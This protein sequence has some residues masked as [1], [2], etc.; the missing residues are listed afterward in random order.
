MQNISLASQIL[1]R[2]LHILNNHQIIFAGDIQDNFAA[3]FNDAIVLTSQFHHAKR[4]KSANIS[5]HFGTI[6]DESLVSSASLLVYY[7]PK[8]KEEAL[9]QLTQLLSIIPKSTEI[10]IVGENRV[11]VRSV[12]NRFDDLLSLQKI[13]T[14][15][16]CSLYYAKLKADVTFNVDNYWQSYQVNESITHSALPGVFSRN[17]LDA[18]SALLINSMIP[19]SKNINKVVN[20]QHTLAFLNKPQLRADVLDL[21]CG[22]GIVPLFLHTYYPN[23]QWT[24]ADAQSQALESAKYNLNQINLIANIIATDMFSEIDGKFD[25][26]ISNPPFHDGKQTD[27]AMT[28]QL[29]Q[30]SP[31]Y[32]RDHGALRIV[33]NGFLPY[34]AFMQQAFGNVD[35]IAKTTQFTVYQSIKYPK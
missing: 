23:I 10:L 25:L 29:I 1:E 9:F 4:L 11:G 34:E 17:H 20:P 31:K 18:G 7:W 14:A 19:N 26:I 6:F 32:L 15:K 13:D 16:R 27:Y 22:A 30:S 33:A 12:E 35:I 3:I 28:Q 5:T 24:L 21:C 2:H 8:T